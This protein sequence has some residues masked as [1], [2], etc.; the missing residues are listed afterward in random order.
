MNFLNTVY[1]LI[2]VT[3]RIAYLRI[4]VF[5]YGYGHIGMI[6]VIAILIKSVNNTIDIFD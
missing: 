4:I 3:Y 2:F 6:K 5:P 1:K